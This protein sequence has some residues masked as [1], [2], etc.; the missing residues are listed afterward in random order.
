MWPDAMDLLNEK[1]CS[2]LKNKKNTSVIASPQNTYYVSEMELGS[3][4]YIGV[5]NFT[6]EI[7]PLY[8]HQ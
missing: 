3:I 4:Y 2:D 1:M 6:V 7:L 8:F 5:T